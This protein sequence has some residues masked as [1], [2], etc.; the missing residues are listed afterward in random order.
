[1]QAARHPVAFNSFFRSK[2]GEESRSGI[3]C[4]AMLAVSVFSTIEMKAI[5]AVS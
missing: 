3:A 4:F 1:V 2:R 5:L